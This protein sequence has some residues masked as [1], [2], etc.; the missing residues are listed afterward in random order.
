[1]K[2]SLQNLWQNAEMVKQSSLEPSSFQLYM[3]AGST[4]ENFVSTEGSSVVQILEGSGAM[5]RTSFVN[6]CATQPPAAVIASSAGAALS[7]IDCELTAAQCS[8]SPRFVSV[9]TPDDPVFSN[10][11]LRVHVT[12]SNTTV[13]AQPLKPARDDALQFLTMADKVFVE[14]VAVRYVETSAM[15]HVTM[16]KSEC[17]VLDSSG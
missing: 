10:T 3:H 11:A 15:Q 8:V 16:T 2:Q 14:T 7:F 1:M 6:N 4:V 13:S 12:S 5:D 17:T 9:E